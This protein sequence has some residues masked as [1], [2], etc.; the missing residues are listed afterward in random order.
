MWRRSCTNGAG[1][2]P[3]GLAAP[4]VL[5]RRLTAA[6]LIALLNAG[7]AV[8]TVGWKATEV[9]SVAER[10]MLGVGAC[11]WGLATAA[12]AFLCRPTYT[13]PRYT[14]PVYPVLPALSMAFNVF[15]LGQL[16]TPAYERFGIWTAVCIA[17]YFLY[18]GA[19]SFNKAQRHEALPT[20]GDEL[21][22]AKASDVVAGGDAKTVE[23]AEAK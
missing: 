11:V 3:A 4:A 5:R 2:P 10:A 16:G 12:F 1:G 8:F 17:G 22:G 6:G 20:R 19:A 7:A 18:S 23:L 9:G 21:A 15:L 13:A 14:A